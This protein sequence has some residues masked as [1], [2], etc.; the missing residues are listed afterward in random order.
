MSMKSSL[1]GA[2]RADARGSL[3]A[4]GDQG[5]QG[6]QGFAEAAGDG[7]GH[8]GE[9]PGARAQ[10]AAGAAREEGRRPGTLGVA[11]MCMCMCV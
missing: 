2:T 8:E 5:P 7:E 4:A 1:L 11:C 10:E 3:P 9:V 6:V